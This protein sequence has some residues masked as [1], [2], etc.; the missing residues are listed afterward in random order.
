MKVRWNYHGSRLLISIILT[1]FYYINDRIN[2]ISH[3]K[4]GIEH[5]SEKHLMKGT[6]VSIWN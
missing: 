4:K 2:Y 6:L 3:I 1:L 5:P